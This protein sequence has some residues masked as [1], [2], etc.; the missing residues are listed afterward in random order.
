MLVFYG[1]PSI[2]FWWVEPGQPQIP[3]SGL[4]WSSRLRM[5]WRN[6]SLRTGHAIWEWS[7]ED[8]FTFTKWILWRWNPWIVPKAQHSRWGI[9][10]DLMLSSTKQ[11]HLYLCIHCWTSN[12]IIIYCNSFPLTGGWKRRCHPDMEQVWTCQCLGIRPAVGHLGPFVMGALQQ[13]LMLAKLG[14]TS[15]VCWLVLVQIL[16]KIKVQK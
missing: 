13:K 3:S 6:W 9:F 5:S 2:F 15:H 4:G 11:F 16:L 14:S 10:R 7:W 8:S 12:G 1:L